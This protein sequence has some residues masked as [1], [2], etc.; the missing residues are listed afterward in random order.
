MP[1]SPKEIVIFAVISYALLYLKDLISTFPLPEHRLPF[2]I[3]T[4]CVGLVF[5]SVG[6]Y[7]KQ[8]IIQLVDN[9]RLKWIIILSVVCLVMSYL[10]GWT[11]LNSYDFGNIKLL[12]YPIAFIGIT[13]C[14]FAS[15]VIEKSRF[16]MIKNILVFYGKNSLLIF[17]FQSL[18]IRLYLLLFNHIEGLNMQLY[19]DNPI[20]HQI[21]S[22]FIVSFIGS[23]LVVATFRFLRK[24]RINIL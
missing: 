12:F 16:V 3:D 2:K 18:L 21:G 10:N 8:T 4:A 1:L 7:A 14:L 23:P 17:G 20:I 13:V 11:N 19:A 15:V 9:A 6:F 24:R 5:F 22:F